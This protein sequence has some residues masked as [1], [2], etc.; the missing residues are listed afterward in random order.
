MALILHKRLFTKAG[1]YI[2]MVTVG[3]IWY[4]YDDVTITRIEL[5]NF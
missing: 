2:L 1:H 3:D 4:W 5:K